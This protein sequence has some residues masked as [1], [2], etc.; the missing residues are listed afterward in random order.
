MK[1]IG[2]DLTGE[3]GGFVGVEDFEFGIDAGEV[4][5]LPEQAGR[6]HAVC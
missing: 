2:G 4:E 3:K 5:M 6:I 1:Q